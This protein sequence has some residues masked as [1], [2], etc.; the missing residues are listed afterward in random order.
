MQK[1]EQPTNNN[2]EEEGRWRRSGVLYKK[3]TRRKDIRVS[4]H[5][6]I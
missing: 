5:S 1:P 4:V 3:A 2:K 6:D